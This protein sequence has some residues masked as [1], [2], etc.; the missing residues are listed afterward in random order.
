MLWRCP[1]AFLEPFTPNPTRAQVKSR[2]LCQ[3]LFLLCAGEWVLDLPHVAQARLWRP[4]WPWWS[5][6][7]VCC[8]AAPLTIRQVLGD[9][10]SAWPSCPPAIAASMGGC[11]RKLFMCSQKAQRCAGSG[12]GKCPK[13][14]IQ[15][16][17]AGVCFQGKEKAHIGATSARGLP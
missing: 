11:F 1:A 3:L 17:V 14:E 9:C 6:R 8:L 10:A 16:L 12:T 5:I 2:R 7:R 15:K 13:C 4:S